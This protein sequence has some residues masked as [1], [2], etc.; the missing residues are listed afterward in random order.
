MKCICE[1]GRFCKSCYSILYY[2]LNKE[3]ILKHQKQKYKE[4][5]N[6]KHKLIINRGNFL[7]TF[8]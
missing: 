3:S 1:Q 8:K 2:K 5:K 6:E 7:L 4:L